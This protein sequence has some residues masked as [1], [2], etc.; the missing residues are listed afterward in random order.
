ME[1]FDLAA[2]IRYLDDTKL[3]TFTGDPRT[4]KIYEASLALNSLKISKEITPNIFSSLEET[5]SNLNL[6]SSKVKAYVTSS[7]EIQAGCMSFSKESCV[8]TLTSAIIN[9]MDFEE[10]KFILGHEL[11]HFLLSHNIEETQTQ[12]SKE[13]YIKTR[14]QEISVDRLGLLAC[15]NIDVATRAVVKTLSGLDEKY[16]KFNMKA[17]LGQLD[18]DLIKNEETKKFSSH[19]SFILRAKALMRFSLSDPYLQ[20]TKETSGTNLIEIDRL[21]QE[22]L[23]TYIDKDLRIDIKEAKELIPFWGY[24]YAYVKN[25]TITKQNQSNLENKFGSNMKEKLIHMITGLSTEEAIK[26]VKIKFINSINNYK[27]VAPNIAKKELNLMI[28]EIEE[29]TNQKGFFNEILQEV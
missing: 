3:R 27:V 5:C 17:F 13:G 1:A 23:N 29:D 20:L 7:P 15:R 4:I 18:E 24:A 11:G 25:G 12:E 22:D 21:I 16:I 19:P 6:D 10:I 14:A 26:E 9:L 8:I 2:S 28:M